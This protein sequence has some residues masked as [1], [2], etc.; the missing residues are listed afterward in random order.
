MFCLYFERVAEEVKIP[1]IFCKTLLHQG[2]DLFLMRIKLLIRAR[3]NK[4]R[5]PSSFKF[6]L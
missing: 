5:I 2:N 3:I 6:Y 1:I 4:L